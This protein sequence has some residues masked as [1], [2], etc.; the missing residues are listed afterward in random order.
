MNTNIGGKNFFQ[1]WY[2]NCRELIHSF[3]AN[4][5]DS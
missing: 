1:M 3:L 5:K 4:F 2:D